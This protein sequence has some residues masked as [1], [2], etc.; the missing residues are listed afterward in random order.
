ME[1][2][3]GLLSFFTHVSSHVDGTRCLPACAVP[4]RLSE[5]GR[6]GWRT[7]SF[8]PRIPK[9]R[10]RQRRRFCLANFNRPREKAESKNDISMEWIE[11]RKLKVGQGKRLVV[12][13]QA[14][15][16]ESVSLSS[17]EACAV[18]IDESD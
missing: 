2:G 1:N 12:S 4:K 14:F 11:K 8:F 3:A 13:K 17:L 18:S 16:K 10:V 6:C 7:T 15:A 5:V 9:T